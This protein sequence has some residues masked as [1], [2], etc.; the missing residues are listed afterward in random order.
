MAKL[1][2]KKGDKVRVLSGDDRGQDGVVLRVY[3][4]K[5]KAVVEGIGVVTKHVKPNADPKN[6]QGGIVEKEAAIHVA[7]LMVI[8]PKTSQPTRTSRTKNANGYSVR[9]SQ[10]SGAIID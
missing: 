5:M 6:P 10:K 3:P 2:I 8:D 1:H 7:K 4:K 9:V